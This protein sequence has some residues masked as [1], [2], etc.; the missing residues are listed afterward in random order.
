MIVT[1]TF[2]GKHFQQMLNRCGIISFGFPQKPPRHS[3]NLMVNTVIFSCFFI[4]LC[5][6]IIAPLFNSLK[7]KIMGVNNLPSGA[8]KFL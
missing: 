6:S 3:R 1:M 8:S 5:V 2:R 7:V 4:I